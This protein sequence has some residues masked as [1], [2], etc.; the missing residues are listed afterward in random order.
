MIRVQ[1]RADADADAIA[2]ELAPDEA[3]LLGRSPSP[4]RLP[5]LWPEAPRRLRAVTIAAPSVSGNHALLWRDGDG[6]VLRDLGS[7]N[8]C[9]L[10]LPS[11]RAASV[12]AGSELLLELGGASGG[13]ARDRPDDA[14]WRDASDFAAGVAHAIERWLAGRRVAAR[15]V[16]TPGVAARGA[17]LVEPIPMA[18]GAELTLVPLETLD[19]R[20][21]LIASALW[22]YV[23]RQNQIF[24]SEEETRREGLVLASPMMRALHRDV[25]EAAR[26]GARLMLIGP[27]G[28]G[29]EGLARLYHRHTGRAGAFVARNCAVLSRELLRSELFGADEGA[30][31]GCTRRI[32]GAVERAHGGT[33]LLDEI[34]E[35]SPEV[36]PMLLRFLDRGEYERMGGTGQE[37]RADVRIVSAT[38]R[39]LR[40]ET[41]RGRF[42]ADLWYRLSIHA[43]DVPPLRERPEDLI[44]YLAAR[45]VDGGALLDRLDAGALGALREHAW[46]GN[47]RELASF[48]DRAA[49]APG[50]LDGDACRRLLDR[51]ALVPG[52]PRATPP[53]TTPRPPD[54]REPPDGLDWLDVARAAAQAFREDR[55]KPAPSTW[56]D[57][58]EFVEK[59]LKPVLFARLSGLDGQ[60]R[61]DLD[62]PR[63]AA[64]LDADR[65][66][67]LKQLNRYF[68]RFGG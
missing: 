28:V 33:L 54:D 38:N 12:G 58:K 37:R 59:Y 1:V 15:V 18:T 65:G 49:A 32:T 3:V 53:P 7:K 56:D 46:A 51:V 68:E 60:A 13:E 26:R 63:L 25:I 29:K 48:A 50:P 9:W 39:E 11:D 22:R 5:P 47:F 43:V 35:L 21:G 40:Q 14:E 10:K 66:T 17:R 62:V 45:P 42:R 31:T 52:A 61:A 64:R 8:G 6:L 36:Q 57:V 19:A 55:D 23:A 20:W 2:V 34:G 44:A 27:S 24:E 4:E 67:A 16:V 41:A 30:F